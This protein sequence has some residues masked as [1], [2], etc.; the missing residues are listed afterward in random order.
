MGLGIDLEFGDNPWADAAEEYAENWLDDQ[1]DDAN[2]QLEDWLG[3][4]PDQFGGQ[5]FPTR[6][7]DPHMMAVARQQL[8]YVKHLG[9]KKSVGLFPEI[10]NLA[11]N[12]SVNWNEQPVY[13]RPDPLATY[14]NTQ[15]IITIGFKLTAANIME[16]KY[17]FEKTLG[18]G[19]ENFCSL[20]NMMYPTY[21][22]VGNY[23]TIAQPP[24]MALKHVQL[25][26]SFGNAERDGM[27]CG[28]FKSCNMVPDF[29]EGAYEDA[30]R[31]GNRVYPKI[32]NVNMVFH[33]L[34]DYTLGW[35]AD[36]GEIA[37]LFPG[38]GSG[39][40]LFEKIGEKIGGS[41]GGEFGETVGGLAGSILGGFLD[42]IIDDPDGYEVGDAVSDL[43]EVGEAAMDFVGGWF[44]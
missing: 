12:Y 23:K 40:D 7:W 3:I 6:Y 39:E 33:V 26:Q 2:R 44:D 10:T 18:R 19:G 21:H 41:I 28:Y 43:E 9:S 34:H 20:S 24:L 31:V 38:I 14:Q 25:L 36:T 11:T 37:E 13:G 16:A 30:K 17:N 42:E 35:E 5:A 1:W 8:L 4:G 27:L 29:K 15:R 22:N 32:I